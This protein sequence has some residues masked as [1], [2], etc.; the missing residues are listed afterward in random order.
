MK[1]LRPAVFALTLLISASAHAEE[2]KVEKDLCDFYSIYTPENLSPE[3]LSWPMA[4]VATKACNS[5]R[6]YRESFEVGREYVSA[7]YSESIAPS[8]QQ[9]KSFLRA[10]FNEKDID[11]MRTEG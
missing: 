8:L 11:H 2:Q 1:L 7:V 4:L 9:A 3:S 6:D 10:Y 5:L